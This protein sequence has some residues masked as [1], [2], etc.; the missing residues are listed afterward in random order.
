MSRSRWDGAGYL[1]ADNRAADSGGVHEDDLVG[2]GHCGA[3][4]PKHSYVDSVG[5]HA[6]YAEEGGACF[7]CASAL[8]GPDHNNC[9]D[10]VRRPLD[11]GGGCTH[12]ERQIEASLRDCHRREQNAKVLGI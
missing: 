5:Y 10:R 4:I 6:G 7:V 11:E 12:M 1:L 9:R 8:C 2:C 3:L